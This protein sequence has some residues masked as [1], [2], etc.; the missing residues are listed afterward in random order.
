[1]YVDACCVL[2]GCMVHS[3]ITRTKHRLTEYSY[4]ENE[5]QMIRNYKQMK[6]LRFWVGNARMFLTILVVLA[7]SGECFTLSNSPLCH[8]SKLLSKTNCRWKPSTFPLRSSIQS[9]TTYSPIPENRNAKKA[10]R[11][12]KNNRAAIRWVVESIEKILEEE[13]DEKQRNPSNQEETH[14]TNTAKENKMLLEA[15]HKFHQG[16]G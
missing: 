4:I 14:H 12:P 10:K 13:H 7:A 16:E 8:Q 6:R 9:T 3:N 11:K 15:L 2:T 5:E 1:M